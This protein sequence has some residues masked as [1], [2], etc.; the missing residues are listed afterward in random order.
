[1][2]TVKTR[3]EWFNLLKDLANLNSLKRSNLVQV[4]NPLEQYDKELSE[5]EKT[6]DNLFEKAKSSLHDAG[7]D[8]QMEGYSDPMKVDIV[9]LTASNETIISAMKKVCYDAQFLS[10]NQMDFRLLMLI[11]GTLISA[12]EYELASKSLNLVK[13]N[14]QNL[15]LVGLRI[16]ARDLA[17][18][19]SGVLVKI[20]EELYPEEEKVGRMHIMKNEIMQIAFSEKRE[21]REAM[22]AYVEIKKRNPQMIETFE[23][24]LE[25][26]R[27]MRE[28][29]M[30]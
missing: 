29:E 5:E 8:L 25:I 1:M 15:K 21:E 17:D 2:S 13:S 7:I 23:L 18:L 26:S 11:A 6:F 27:L 19:I 20:Q 16:E 30:L 10:K 9:F 28:A 12:E 14:W 22:W 4:R 24:M 3:K